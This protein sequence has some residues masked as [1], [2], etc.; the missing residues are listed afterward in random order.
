MADFF[1]SLVAERWL[2]SVAKPSRS[3]VHFSFFVCVV[4]TEHAPS[5]VKC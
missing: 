3:T 5:V 4:E 1:C 2:V